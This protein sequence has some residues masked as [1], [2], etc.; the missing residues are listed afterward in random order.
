MTACAE[1]ATG[2]VLVLMLLTAQRSILLCARTPVPS[3]VSTMSGA[4]PGRH[5]QTEFGIGRASSVQL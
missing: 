2:F 4:V 5:K 1:V 3:I